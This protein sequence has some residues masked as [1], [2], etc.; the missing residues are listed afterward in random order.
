MKSY[1]YLAGFLIFFFLQERLRNSLIL[2]FDILLPKQILT[3]TVNCS[4]NPPPPPTYNP[5]PWVM[6]PSTCKQ[7]NLT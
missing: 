4:P 1:Y 5:A 2:K 6:C 3:Y 7:K